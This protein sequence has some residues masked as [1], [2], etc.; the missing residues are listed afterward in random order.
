MRKFRVAALALCLL[1]SGAAA[2]ED[3]FAELRQALIENV[4][5]AIRVTG[6]ITGTERLDPRI[7][8]AMSAVPR[9]LFVPEPLQPYAYINRPLPVGRGQTE[10]QPYIVALMTELAHVERGA[11]VLLVGI[12]GGW[13][14]AILAEIGAKVRVVELD[15]EIERAAVS[16]L[17]SGG[18]RDVETRVADPYFGWGGAQFDAI[19]VRH[20]INE[21]PA[22]LLKQLKPGGRMV[23]P[24]E[25][26]RDDQRLTL[27]TKDADG[28]ASQRAILPV[29]F[30][31]LP[32]GERI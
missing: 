12:G 3:P 24:V 17:E 14:A 8:A 11:N 23:L 2:A 26:G 29:T 4:I 10:S 9:H 13:H 7:V 31:R 32:G 25:R 27:V 16:R 15:G 6:S 5:A 18:Y 22:A 19:I 21:V 1:S 30:N 28:R 20:A